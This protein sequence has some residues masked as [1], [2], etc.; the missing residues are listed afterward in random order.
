MIDKTSTSASSPDEAADIELAIK[1]TCAEIARSI[2]QMRKDQTEIDQLKAETR[3][4][5]GKLKAT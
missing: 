1:D 2:E 3:A 4:M 5:L